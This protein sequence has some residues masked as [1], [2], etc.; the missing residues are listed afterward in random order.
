MK[1]YKCLTVIKV[2]KGRFLEEVNLLKVIN[3]LSLATTFS[4]LPSSTV[5]IE[6][7]VN[8]LRRTSYLYELGTSP[9]TDEL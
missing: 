8:I 1:I 5:Y 4:Q 6:R 7:Y 3:W 9:G 2:V